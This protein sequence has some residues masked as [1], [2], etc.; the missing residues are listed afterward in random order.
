MVNITVDPAAVVSAKQPFFGGTI[1][2]SPSHACRCVQVKEDQKFQL[3]RD[4][5]FNDFDV[6]LRRANTTIFDG[7]ILQSLIGKVTRSK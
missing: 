7:Q 2:S 3:E 4:I 5:M 6:M 1:S